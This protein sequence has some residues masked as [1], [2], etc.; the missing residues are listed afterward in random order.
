[1]KLKPSNNAARR[2]YLSASPKKLGTLHERMAFVMGLLQRER[3]NVCHE[4]WDAIYDLE[5]EVSYHE[6]Q[7]P[8]C[9]R[10][11]R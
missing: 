10:R 3:E 7:L 2:A 5:L 6:P 1:M 11:T 9:G 8:P 4:L